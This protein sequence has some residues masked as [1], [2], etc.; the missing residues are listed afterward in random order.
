MRLNWLLLTV[1]AFNLFFSTLGDVSAK[2]WGVTTNP[3]WLYFG[4][5]IN[6]MTVLT[7]MVVIRLGGLA[8]ATAVVL[9][10]TILINTII[11]FAIFGEALSLS[12]WVGIGLALVAIAL[13]S[14]QVN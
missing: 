13:L 11:G 4:F 10:L 7:F 12:Q 3:K 1:M 9:L 6:I 5:F 8:I 2:L 14:F